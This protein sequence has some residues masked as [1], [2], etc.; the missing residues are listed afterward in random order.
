[1]GQS[2][3]FSNEGNSQIFLS[4]KKNW[5]CFLPYYCFLHI[6]SYVKRI[7]TGISLADAGVPLIYKPM[8][9]NL[10]REI[11]QFLHLNDNS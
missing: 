7:C 11:K 3:L 6:T 10:F 2:I 1:M 5:K 4:I 8:S 9:K